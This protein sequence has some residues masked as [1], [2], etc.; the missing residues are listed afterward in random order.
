MESLAATLFD[1]FPGETD[2][3]QKAFYKLFNRLAK[4]RIDRFNREMSSRQ[5][6]CHYLPSKIIV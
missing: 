2:I 4:R 1:M 5:R 3:I 6:A